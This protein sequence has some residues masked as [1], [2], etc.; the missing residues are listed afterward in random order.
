MGLSPNSK[1]KILGGLVALV[2]IGICCTPQFRQFVSIPSELRLAEGQEH[3][4]QIGV[5]MSIYVRPNRDGVVEFPGATKSR[6]QWKLDPAPFMRIQPTTTGSVTIELRFLGLVPFR[7]VAVDVVPRVHVVPGGHSIGVMVRSEGVLLVRMAEVIDQNGNKHRP[8]MEAGLAEGDLILRIN[9]VAVS[10]DDFLA[11]MVDRAGQEGVPVDLQI[12]RGDLTFTRRIIPVRCAETGRYKVGMWVRDSTA[13]VGTL[14]FYHPETKEYAALGHIITDADTQRPVEVLD[15]RIVRARV[16][17]IHQGKRGQPGEK[18]GVFAE[19]QAVL[20][21]IEENTEFGITGRL[22]VEPGNPWYPDGLPVAMATEVVEGPASILTV[23]DGQEMEQFAVE[24][25]RVARQAGPDVKGMLIQVVDKRLLERTGGI[26]QGMSG[27]PI[28]QK[29]RI[30][31]AVTHVLV[32]DP[33]RGYGVFA[34]W[35]VE[36]LRRA[37]RMIPA[38]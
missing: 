36:R 12:K 8:A 30:V 19:Q 32:N 4:L 28:I 14:T 31:G 21:T 25:I 6:D 13:G 5:P 33:T 3:Y 17:G 38:A 23:L 35:M 15:G 20:G 10:S 37:M 7:R 1:R 22:L 11:A 27:S 16:S 9:G 26:I 34:E 24:I 18:I 2:I 29:G